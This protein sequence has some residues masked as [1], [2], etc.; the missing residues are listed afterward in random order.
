MKNT[1]NLRSIA[2]KAITQVLEQGQSLSSVIPEL[3]QRVSDKDK[4][5]L[6]ELCFGVM[7]VLPQLEWFM[8]QLMAKPLKG[9]QR[10]FH[11][12]I[13]VGLYQLTYTRIPAHAALAETVNGA[14]N[15]KR[16][17]LKGLINGVLRQ[18]QRQQQELVERSNKH[19]NQH[20][21]PK[22][23]QE[24]IQKSYPQNWQTIIDA[25]NQKPPMWLR[26]NQLH[27]T[28]NEYLSLL[29]NANIEAELDTKHPNAIRLLN[30]CPVHSLP[31]FNQGWV[32]IQDRSA[33]GCAELLT[34]CNGEFILDLCA[35][36]GGKTTHILEI[37]PKSK[38]LA[39]DIDEQRLKRVKENLQRLNLHAVVKTGDGRLPHEW[40]AG[41]QFDRIL[42]DAPCSAT[43]VI[44][45]HPDIKWLRRNEDIDQLV[46]LQSEILDAIWP[47]LKKNGTLVYATC[48]I[49][50]QENSEQI[51]AFLKRHTDAV[52][53]ETGSLEKP[54]TQ[55]IPEV[56]GG[57]GFFYARL[58]KP[59]I[60]L[61]RSR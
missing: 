24:R 14:I 55:I 29:E 56:E 61:S 8:S 32:T 13:M 47:Y 15:L 45:R 57:D 1:Y 59:I 50:P 48:S 25:N 46:T 16:P 4:A 41:E 43:G 54:G 26:V 52:L 39:I 35:A 3:Q 36:P 40:A 17:Q 44:R 53:S 9:K 28:A 23:L 31:G 20:L 21:H 19:I 42:L 18:F 11:Y 51:K 37:A 12:L 34:P 7:R 2:A 58:I 30:P 49:L 10:I 33:Q 60:S 38:V 22:W 27:H 6:Q 5:L